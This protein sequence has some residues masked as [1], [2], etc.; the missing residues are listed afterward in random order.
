LS[1]QKGDLAV[2]TEAKSPIKMYQELL[3]FTLKDIPLVSTNPNL[4]NLPI[5]LQIHFSLYL[6]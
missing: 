3:L 4:P 2:Q 5:G 6:F 1:Q